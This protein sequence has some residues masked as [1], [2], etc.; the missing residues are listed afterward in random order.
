MGLFAQIRKWFGGK[1]SLDPGALA[2]IEEC[3]LKA[4]L[5][6]DATAEILEVTKQLHAKSAD[7]QLFLSDLK[8]ALR[9]NLLSCSRQL[10]LHALPAPAVLCL[11]GVNGSGKTTTCAKIAHRLAGEGKHVVLAACDTFRAGAVDQLEIWAQRS[12]A[13]FVKGKAGSDPASVAH[14][15]L[16]IALA[17]KADC[18]VLDTAGRLH[19]KAGLMDEAKKITRVLKKL[20]PSAPDETLLVLDATNGQNA[21]AQVAE[22][23]AALGVTGL[24]LTKMDS[25]CKAGIIVAL[26]KRFGIPVKFAGS[27]EK[28]EDLQVFDPDAFVHALVGG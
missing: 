20:R 7:D 6:P 11:V 19:T 8:S 21:L 1:S 25:G 15:A 9:H 16:A 18:V 2:Q 5:G 10:L 24:V 14:E 22:F 23:H 27:G 28:M 3:L 12:G 26:E 4:D 13:F 17:R